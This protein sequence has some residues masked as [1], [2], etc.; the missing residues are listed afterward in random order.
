ML[1]FFENNGKTEGD[2]WSP[3]QTAVY[4]RYNASG[5]Q[6][7]WILIKPSPHLEESLQAELES[8]PCLALSGKSRAARL[9]VMFT[10]FA[11]RNWPDYIAAQRTKVEKLV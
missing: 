11:L 3:R 4:H 2:P 10:Y 6:S 8:V 7:S 9:H 5:N 1:H